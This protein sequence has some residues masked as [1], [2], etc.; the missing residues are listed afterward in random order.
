MRPFIVA[1]ITGSLIFLMT[2]ALFAQQRAASDSSSVI[3]E[4]YPP[5]ATRLRLA[6]T[7]TAL[8]AGWYGAALGESFAWPN[9]PAAKDQRIPVV[10]PW[11]TI[12]HAGCGSS[13]PNCTTAVAVVRAI[14]AGLTSIGQIGGLAV[15]AESAFLPTSSDATSPR[16]ARAAGPPRRAT[17]P[18]VAISA[19]PAGVGLGVVGVF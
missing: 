14:L 6:I 8:F 9:A 3:P 17:Q 12:A 2:P 19:A 11:M 18:Q 5:R 4:D 7:G 1:W 10:G 15:L 13:E 16:H